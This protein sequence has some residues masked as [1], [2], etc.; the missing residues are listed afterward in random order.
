LRGVDLSGTEFSCI[1]GG[2]Q[3]S[4][5]WS[6][7]GDQPLDQASTYQAMV[8]WHIDVVR[9]P[10]NEDCW[11]GINGVKPAFGGTSYRQ[12]VVAEVA[13]IHRAGMDAILDLHWSSPG[14]YAAYGQQPLPDAD[15]SISFWR[16]VAATF[17]SDPEV[18]FDLYNEPFLYA[19]YMTDPSQDAWECWLDGCSLNQFISNHQIGPDG[20]STGYTTQ[21]A[22]RS[23]GMQQIVD[24]IRLTGA[25][26]PVLINGLDWANDDSGWLTHAP[27]DPLGQIIVGAHLYPGEACQDISCWDTTFGPIGQRYPILLGETGDST[28]GSATF[29][30]IVL[31]W[32]DSHHISY[33]AWT[34]NPWTNPNDVLVQNWKG[35]PT[36]G[37]GIYFRSHLQQV[38]AHG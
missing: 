30:P 11:L 37:E 21:Y 3:T 8:S 14:A 36:P 10:L 19:S 29:L 25:T 2:T 27:R 9:V 16:S 33:L 1:Q 32:A 18:I 17:K 4:R 12:A 38:M 23:A 28:N 6:I 35:T 26:Q 24:T 13:T 7:Y 20:K 34:W 22:W 5:G 31:P 15:H